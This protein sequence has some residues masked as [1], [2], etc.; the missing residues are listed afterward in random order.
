MCFKINSDYKFWMWSGNLFLFL[1]YFVCSAFSQA[2]W[3]LVSF[4]VSWHICQWVI[5]AVRKT[6]S[7]EN[8]SFE[9]NQ[10]FP[11]PCQLHIDDTAN[12]TFT[13][14]GHLLLRE[15][16]RLKPFFT[17][18]FF[19]R[20]SLWGNIFIEGVQTKA[21]IRLQNDPQVLNLFKIR[22]LNSKLPHL[23]ELW[24]YKL[25]VSLSNGHK[26]QE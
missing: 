19:L 1:L 10:K 23:S 12:V 26:R 14:G 22:F 17:D 6:N 15:I 8:F 3:C 2:W 13:E 4:E 9:K 18:S 16:K 25:V 7:L 5:S 24:S 21:V 11:G 20:L